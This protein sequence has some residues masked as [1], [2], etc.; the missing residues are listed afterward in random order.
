MRILHLVITLFITF[1]SWAQPVNPLN[2]KIRKVQDFIIE[3]KLDSASFYLNKLQNDPYKNLLFRIINNKKVAYSEHNEFISKLLDDPNIEYEVISNYINSSV[4][5]PVGSKKINL[6]YV[7]LKWG[8]VSALRDE[9]SLEAAS[10]EQKKIEK[11]VSNFNE[12]EVNVLRAKTIIKTHPVVMLLINRDLEKG[13][14]LALESLKVSENLE[15]F[16]LQIYFLSH[17]SDFL[18]VERKLKE[19]IKI[20][21]RCLELEDK[22]PKKS[23]YYN[24]T[25]ANLI[26]AYIFQGNNNK[27]VVQLLEELYNTPSQAVTYIYYAQLISS[28]DEKSA[29]KQEILNKFQAKDVAELASK[30]IKLGNRLNSNQ[31][32]KLVNMSSKALAA[33]DFYEEAIAYKEKAIQITRKIYSEDL[34]KFL[35]KDKTEQA[36]KVKEI[37]ISIE[38]DKTKLYIIIASLSLTL[39]LITLLVLVKIRKQSKELSS[40]N[41]LINNALTEK[42]VLIKEVHHR[43][44]NN[45]QIITSLLELQSENIDDEKTLDRINQ[46]KN[47]IKSMAL[48]HQKLY[49]NEGGLIGF[50]DYICLLIKEISIIHQLDV[51]IMTTIIVENIFFDVDTAIPLGLI[52]NEI[53]TNAYKHAFK[54]DRINKLS[55]SINQQNDGDYKLIIQDNGA[56]ISSS[57]QM[58]KSKSIGLTLVRRLVKQLQGN[59]DLLEDHG[60]RFE[61]IFK[62]SKK[63]NNIE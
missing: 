42:E 38:K 32:F 20:N 14:K 5:K 24:I 61:I 12:K 31:F 35:A 51:K 2:E 45:F 49:R 19:F 53:I 29:L 56:G 44:K 54:N 58:E 17:Y 37:E 30:F 18:V 39:L 25:I 40:K 43:V 52:I 3:N 28:L 47:R 60:T 16:E 26:N 36:L 9:A 1:I 57:F 33:H 59:L 48:I 13:K 15:D 11:Y 7:F 50:N 46:S 23:A 4:H 8:Q 63:R 27:R 6:E 62:D 41:Q 34:S 55:I 22:L 21:E 10:K